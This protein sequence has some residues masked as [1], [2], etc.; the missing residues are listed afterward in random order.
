MLL[1]KKFLFWLSNIFNV[2]K[3]PQVDHLGWSSEIKHLLNN[4]ANAHLVLYH[5]GDKTKKSELNS[6]FWKILFNKTSFTEIHFNAD[7]ITKDYLSGSIDFTQDN[8]EFFF[9]N[10]LQL[11]EKYIIQNLPKIIKMLEVDESP[12]EQFE[13]NGMMIAIED[14]EYQIVNVD[15]IAVM[16]SVAL[17]HTEK[18]DLTVRD[19]VKTAPRVFSN[20]NKLF[21]FD[22]KLR[23]VGQKFGFDIGEKHV[24][25]LNEL[26]FSLN[27][28][29]MDEEQLK[30]Q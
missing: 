2:T 29:N 18:K 22:L 28:A 23:I 20:E 15:R 21:I 11:D 24:K 16:L 8:I 12:A 13:T 26:L 17:N 14:I 3:Q 27:S 19:C 6:E 4:Y 1:F 5:L 7:E 30:K 10:F 25:K 9:E